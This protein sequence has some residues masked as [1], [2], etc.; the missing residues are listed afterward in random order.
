MLLDGK[1]AIAMINPTKNTEMPIQI[2]HYL[3]KSYN[4]YIELKSKRGGG[5]H[6]ISMHN[7]DY[8]FMHEKM[9]Y[10]FDHSAYKFLEQ[11]KGKINK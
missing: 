2:N 4:E 9:S 10:A 7:L 8:F 5:V 11:I 6:D 3:L 1:H